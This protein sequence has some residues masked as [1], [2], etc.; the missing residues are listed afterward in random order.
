MGLESETGLVCSYS[1]FH[2]LISSLTST[3]LTASLSQSTQPE[4]VKLLPPFEVGNMTCLDI[5]QNT[6]REQCFGVIEG[7]LEPFYWLKSV[8][9]RWKNNGERNRFVTR[10]AGL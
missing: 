8:G 1:Q 5:P 4:H 2:G 9:T 10:A 7:Q 3:M 6:I